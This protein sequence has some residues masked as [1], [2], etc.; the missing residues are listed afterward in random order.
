M[1][2]LQRDAFGL[3]ARLDVNDGAPLELALDTLDNL[4]RIA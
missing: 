4:F 2:L 1:V 3:D